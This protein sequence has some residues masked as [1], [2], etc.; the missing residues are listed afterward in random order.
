M[1]TQ[2]T[3]HLP[4]ELLIELR[5]Q[6]AMEGKSVDDLAAEAVRVGLDERHWSDLLAYG[7]R[8]GLDSGYSEADV[9]EIVKKRR[10]SQER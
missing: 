1:A 9:P 5:A 7:Q 4:E 6:A 2:N 8:K 10:K 3:I